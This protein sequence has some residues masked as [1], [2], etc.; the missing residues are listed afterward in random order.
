MSPN[1]IQAELIGGP[2]DGARVEVMPF[3]GQ[4][5]DS[6]GKYIRGDQKTAKG[7]FKFEG[8]FNQKGVE[9]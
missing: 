6:H 4:L 8:I 5:I 7:R 9:K 1:P 2:K 3:V